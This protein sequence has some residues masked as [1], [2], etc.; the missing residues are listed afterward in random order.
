[1]SLCEVCVFSLGWGGGRARPDASYCRT[2]VVAPAPTG[3][4]ALSGGRDSSTTRVY[5]V[6][7]CSSSGSSNSFQ[8][9][10]VWRRFRCRLPAFG[11]GLESWTLRKGTTSKGT[12][13]SEPP[14]RYPLHKT[15]SLVYCC[16]SCMGLIVTHGCG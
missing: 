14:P 11:E 6:G 13:A 2:V 12:F 7:P 5:Q 1:M 9:K 4:P 15:L 8:G 16:H 10:C 3:W